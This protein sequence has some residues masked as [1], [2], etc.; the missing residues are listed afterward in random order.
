M[1]LFSS[2]E[3]L[4]DKLMQQTFSEFVDQSG[5][6]QDGPTSTY[7]PATGTNVMGYTVSI[8]TP[9]YRRDYN[10]HE[11]AGEVQAGDVEI[12]VSNKNLSQEI[13]P[14]AKV[15]IG[16][17]AYD[18]IR[19]MPVAKKGTVIQKLHCRGIGNA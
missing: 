17:D 12:I 1:S 3:S 11:I 7:D 2:F 6:I 5:L 18:V 19:V 8:A 9:V 10:Q 16:S 14:S 13:S 4:R 15:T